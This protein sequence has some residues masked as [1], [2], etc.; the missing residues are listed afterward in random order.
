MIRKGK[1]HIPVK[2]IEPSSSSHCRL[3]IPKRQT[4]CEFLTKEEKGRIRKGKTRIPVKTIEPS[5]SLDVSDMNFAQVNMKKKDGYVSSEYVLTANWNSV[6][7][8]NNLKEGDAV[9][10]WSFRVEQKLHFALV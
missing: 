3:W 9:Q 8:R 1:T 5:S 10:I 6:R 7:D 4:L 2:I